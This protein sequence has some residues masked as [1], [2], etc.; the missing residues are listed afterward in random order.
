MKYYSIIAFVS[1][2]VHSLLGILICCRKLKGFVNIL[3][4]NPERYKILSGYF[5]AIGVVMFSCG[6]AA[7]YESTASIIYIVI[8]TVIVS[9]ILSLIRYENSL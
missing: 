8:A 1:A 7:L 4:K 3:C 6:F 9:V 5:I 2:A